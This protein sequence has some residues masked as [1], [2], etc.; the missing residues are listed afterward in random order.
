MLRTT[1]RH[2]VKELLLVLFISLTSANIYSAVIPSPSTSLAKVGESCM[3]WAKKN[4]GNLVIAFEGLGAFRGK[5]AK[6]LYAYQDALKKGDN[7]ALPKN[8]SMAYVTDN[9]LIKNLDRTYNLTEV[10]SLPHSGEGKETSISFHC[11]KAWHA[12]HKDNFKLVILGHS[13]GGNAAKRLMNT[14]YKKLPKLKVKAMLSL[15]PR[16]KSKFITKPNI[17]KHIVYYQK[18]FLRGYPYKDSRGGNFTENIVVPGKLISGPEG[19]NHANLT[20]YQDVQRT[21]LDLIRN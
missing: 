21:Y 3:I 1:R 8:E 16:L 19:N 18:G 6:K 2:N 14:L 17:K 10:L 7:P 13:F 5:A 15:D 9:L 11:A 12:V 4:K 20:L